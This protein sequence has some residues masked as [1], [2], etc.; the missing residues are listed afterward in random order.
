MWNLQR[1]TRRPRGHQRVV[2]HPEK[3]AENIFPPLGVNQLVSDWDLVRV[4]ARGQR[5][6]D[7]V[8]GL[9][10]SATL[11]PPVKGTRINDS[12]ASLL[13]LFCCFFPRVTCLKVRGTK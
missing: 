5:P 4:I 3:A 10:T 7:G 6:W 2:R 13:L 1:G 12:S 11:V 9:K 8:S